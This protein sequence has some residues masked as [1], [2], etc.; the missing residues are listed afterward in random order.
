MKH[1]ILLALTIGLLLCASPTRSESC[2]D[3]PQSGGHNIVELSGVLQSETHWGP[4]NFGESPK[5]DSKFV[6]FVLNADYEFEIVKGVEFADPTK[7]KIKR[8]Q[9]FFPSREYSRKAVNSMKGRHIHVRGSVWTAKTPGDVT[10]VNL[11]VT[12][13]KP[14]KGIVPLSCV[15]E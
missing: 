8:I 5:T 10:D 13:A 1:T 4:P 9:L 7:I 2:P 6:A 15:V 11:T 14:Q 12:D 3:I